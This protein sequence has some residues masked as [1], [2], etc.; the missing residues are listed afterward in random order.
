M[1]LEQAK[2]DPASVFASPI[3]VCNASELSRDQKIEI[4]RRWEY[5]ARELQVAAEENMGEG[6]GRLLDDVLHAL[7]QLEVGVDVDNSPPTKQGGL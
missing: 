4:L 6:P 1:D 7:H 3:A 5:D 2:L